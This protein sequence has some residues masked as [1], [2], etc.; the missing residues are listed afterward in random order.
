ML[1]LL[2]IQRL[3]NRRGL[4]EVQLVVSDGHEGI[5]AALKR[6]FLSV[7]W[8]RCRV[9]FMRNALNKVSY[10]D[11]KALARELRALFKLTE[12]D[13]CLQA[14]EEIALRWTAMEN[15]SR[16]PHLTTSVG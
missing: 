1:H 12:R 9:H 16:F 6:M 13:L 8:Q 15:A 10:N 11:Q 7:T 3:K 2:Q 4:R 14:A 5:Q